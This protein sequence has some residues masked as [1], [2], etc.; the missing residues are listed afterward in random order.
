MLISFKDLVTLTQTVDNRG[1]KVL[2]HEGYRY[3]KNRARNDAIYWRYWRVDCRTPLQTNLFDIDD[4][5]PNMKV[6]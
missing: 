2:I 4:E 1:G 3:Q 6:C 5:N